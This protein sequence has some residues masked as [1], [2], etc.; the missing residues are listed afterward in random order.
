MAEVKSAN[1]SEHTIDHADQ[2]RSLDLEVN[3]FTAAPMKTVGNQGQRFT[4][5][6]DLIKLIAVNYGQGWK[7]KDCSV[8]LH[9]Q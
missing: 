7:L 1:L 6:R 5:C 3:K 4:R 8:I 9:E 2:F